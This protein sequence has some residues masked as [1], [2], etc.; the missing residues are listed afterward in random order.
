MTTAVS[1]VFYNILIVLDEVNKIRWELAARK[2]VNLEIKVSS[3]KFIMTSSI[4]IQSTI[5]RACYQFRNLLSKLYKWV[6]VRRYLTPKQ[7]DVYSMRFG[8]ECN[9]FDSWLN[10]PQQFKCCKIDL[11]MFSSFFSNPLFQSIYSQ[12][13][14]KD[15]LKISLDLQPWK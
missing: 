11:V 5:H 9:T 3:N 13:I 12:N 2:K 6:K 1:F 4:E 7:S 14:L 15:V 8:L 10:V